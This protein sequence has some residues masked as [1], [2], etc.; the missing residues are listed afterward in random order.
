MVQARKRKI[1]PLG[2]WCEEVLRLPPVGAANPGPLHL[3]PY[4]REI[5]DAC[6]DE[7]Y[8]FVSVLK[9]AQVGFSLILAGALAHYMFR[10]P[11]PVVMIMPTEND[12]RGLMVEQL[13]PLYAESPELR[14]RFPIPRPGKSGNRDTITHR[15][16]DGWRLDVI[17]AG[18]PSAIRRRT[19]RVVC[20]DELDAAQN[21]SEGDIYQI[22][23][24]RSLAWPTRRILAGGTPL[25]VETSTIAR[26]YAESDGR[27]F[28]VPCPDCGDFA[29]I[30]WDRITW[31]PGCYDD[32]CCKCNACGSLIPESHKRTM[33]N[34]GKWVV[35]RPEVR[36]H[37]GF[38][39]SSLVALLPACSWAKLAEKFDKAGN[40]P[41]LLQP[42]YNLDLGLPFE[43]AGEV[44]DASLLQSRVEDFS[45]DN[46]P[47]AVIF[48]TV[49]VDVQDDRLELVFCG[50][51][52]G[53]E[54]FIL[55]HQVI[56]GAVDD[57]L[58]W[59][60]VDDV[61]RLSFRHI[62]AGKELRI[63]AMCIDGG[64]GG[65]MRT[66]M[67]FARHRRGRRVI[68]IKGQSGFS[69][70][71]IVASN[72]KFRGGGRLWIV[73]VDAIKSTIFARLSR[74]AAIHL[75]NTL[76]PTFFEQMQSERIETR[77]VP[78]K[79][80]KFFARLRGARAEA[81]DATCYATAAYHSLPLNHATIGHREAVLGITTP[82]PPSA[83]P[84]PPAVLPE[85][86]PLPESLEQSPAPA[87]LT[88]EEKRLIAEG[89]A[90]RWAGLDDSRWNRRW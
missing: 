77:I 58:T 56:H 39:I 76:T 38:R 72:S 57:N 5:A 43:I 49:G 55:S 20:F 59:A 25:S 31:T 36:G 80:K 10:D 6:S 88:A 60:Q 4:Q 29:E 15:S 71:P 62:T 82:I 89:E 44:I 50:W 86:P 46:I 17:P 65:H 42:F 83:P 69:R 70:L 14:D 30:T 26:L 84:P 28:T 85:E 21:R 47:P 3:Y 11:S 67:E 13:E 48:L 9:S 2:D 87:A 66:V 52:R 34:S 81:L 32:V 74:G 41:A 68:C 7:K 8:E 63:D 64:D 18:N 27:I 35:T 78:G 51:S 61:L 75:S 1:G 45:L 90:S 53:G 24:Q 33:V 16:G 23:V 73:G 12:A 37:A 40:D 79:P 22:G 54:C 19:A